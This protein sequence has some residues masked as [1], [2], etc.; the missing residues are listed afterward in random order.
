MT[1]Y[2]YFESGFGGK[3]RIIFN[4]FVRTDEEDGGLSNVGI[5]RG[6]SEVTQNVRT[7]FKDSS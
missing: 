3:M 6:C 5:G 1:Y 7:S 2:A 4:V